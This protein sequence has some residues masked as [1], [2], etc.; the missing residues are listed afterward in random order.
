ME[1]SGHVPAQRVAPV[2]AK[3][4]AVS[5]D[6]SFKHLQYEHLYT[7]SDLLPLFFSRCSAP[8]LL[9]Q[10]HTAFYP[11]IQSQRLPLPDYGSAH[12][13]HPSDSSGL[14]PSLQHTTT[15]PSLRTSVPIVPHEKPYDPP[16]IEGPRSPLPLPPM[17]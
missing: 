13:I 9:A 8:P 16:R 7:L 15:S 4:V 6:H 5:A 12:P 11:I 10:M 3:L 17:R 1:R 14:S 2:A